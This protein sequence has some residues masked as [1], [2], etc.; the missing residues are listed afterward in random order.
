MLLYMCKHCRTVY[1]VSYDNNGYHDCTDYD[2]IYCTD[3]SNE[4]E[5][6]TECGK[7]GVNTELNRL[8][9]MNTKMGN[10]LWKKDE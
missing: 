2:T 7:C 3:E 10:I 9:D 8:I 6:W 1:N 5:V 4:D